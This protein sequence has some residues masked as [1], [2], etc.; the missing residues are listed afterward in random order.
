MDT[1]WA[2]TRLVSTNMQFNN[3]V[4]QRYSLAGRFSGW[5]ALAARIGGRDLLCF[6]DV[7]YCVVSLSISE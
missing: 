1:G 4:E 2:L 5:L 3:G 7:Q 6:L